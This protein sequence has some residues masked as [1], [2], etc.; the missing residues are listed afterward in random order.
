MFNCDLVDLGCK[1]IFITLSGGFYEDLL[2]KDAMVHTNY[3]K[4]VTAV[5]GKVDC[6]DVINAN[7]KI[8]VVD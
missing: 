6:R 7:V 1:G 2:I 3:V 8:N 4:N 5:L